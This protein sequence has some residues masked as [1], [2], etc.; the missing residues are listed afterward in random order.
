M[1]KNLLKWK[2]LRWGNIKTGSNFVSSFLLWSQETMPQCLNYKACKCVLSGKLMWR[3]CSAKE[4]FVKLKSSW[5]HLK[6]QP[7]N[8]Q[9][10]AQVH[11]PYFLTCVH[12]RAFI[13]RCSVLFKS[14]YLIVYCNTSLNSTLEVR[15]LLLC[16]SGVVQLV[17]YEQQ[18]YWNWK[19]LVEWLHTSDTWK[20]LLHFYGWSNLKCQL[21]AT[22]KFY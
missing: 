6:I 21:D 4:E 9:M 14:R 13:T 17:K 8:H 7:Q 11:F 1:I 12:L 22:R 18:K 19:E 10:L 15:M 16:L 20:V 2:I 3:Y 5:D